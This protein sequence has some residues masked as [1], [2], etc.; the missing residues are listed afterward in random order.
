MATC[1]E[2]LK[3]SSIRDRL[4]MEQ[5]QPGGGAALAKTPGHEFSVLTVLAPHGG[6]V[7]WPLHILHWSTGDMASSEIFKCPGNTKK[8]P[9]QARGP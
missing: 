6:L 5:Q 3:K 8:Q 4:G 9:G 7:Q 1:A 2:V